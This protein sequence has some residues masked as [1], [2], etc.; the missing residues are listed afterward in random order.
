MP[1]MPPLLRLTGR[2]FGRSAPARLAAV[3]ERMV[4]TMCIAGT[5]D[6]VRDKVKRY[7]G[8]ADEI[9]LVTPS[10][11]LEPGAISEGYDAIIDA[12]RR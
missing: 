2:L 12:F 6:E 1:Y 4:R 3:S 9:S 7:E 8:W 11:M 10:F 5:P